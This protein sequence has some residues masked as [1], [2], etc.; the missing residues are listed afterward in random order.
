MH[1]T[2]IASVTIDSVIRMDKKNHPQAH[3]EECKYKIKKIQ[4]SRLINTKL[5]SDS[6]PDS[7]LEV[8]SKSDTE[9]MAKLK[10][11]SDS[12]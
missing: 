11:R 6:E 3:L 1:Y 2:C 4:M 8:E 12:E 10:S 7:E 9:L 5:K